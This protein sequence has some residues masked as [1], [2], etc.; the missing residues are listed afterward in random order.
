MT[1]QEWGPG[2][3]VGVGGYFRWFISKKLKK[4]E[5]HSDEAVLSSILC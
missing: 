3:G 5:L 4:T 1:L 2:K